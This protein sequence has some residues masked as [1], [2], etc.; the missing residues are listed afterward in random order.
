MRVD[1]GEVRLPDRIAGQIDLAQDVPRGRQ[2]RVGIDAGEQK[3]V[4]VT[5]FVDDS[6]PEIDILTI[7]S[8]TEDE[9]VDRIRALRA[10]RETARH[11]NA[12]R[13]LESDARA[14]RNVMPALIECAHADATLG[15][16][17]EVLR[18]VYGSYDGGPE[19]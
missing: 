9:Q 14:A 7:T 15:E 18:G 1:G 12:L 2:R 8:K 11:A 16:I 3:I 6:A 17:V 19:W 10:R 13:Q 4:G 5:D